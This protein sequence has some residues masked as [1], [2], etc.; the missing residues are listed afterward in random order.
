MHNFPPD[1]SSRWSAPPP[2]LR[3]LGYT[4][5]VTL[6]DGPWRSRVQ[7]A[8]ETFLE[9]PVDDVLKGF[10][11]RAGLPAPGH[12]LS[13]W[14]AELTHD[15][16][17][18]W[19]SGLARLGAS[20]RDPAYTERARVLA[21]GWAATLPADGD[22][23]MTTYRWEKT[24]CGLV[25][26]AIYGGWDEGLEL[27]R[28]ITAAA[29]RTI[30]RTRTIPVPSEF[31]GN[32]PDG[33][34]E[35]YT[36]AENLYRGYLAGGDEILRR[37]AGTWHYDAFWDHFRTRPAPGSR[38]HPPVWLHAYSHVNSFASAAAAYGV[39]GDESF[40]DVAANGH[41]WVVQTQCYAT[42]GFG[43]GELTVPDDG[44]LG[45][46]L[47]WRTDTAEI[48]C[49]SWAA[50]KLCTALTTA[51]GQ[52]RY[53]DWAERLAYSGIGA[54]PPVR[55]DGTSP[56]YHDYRLGT[57]TMLPFWDHWPCC[58]G[59]YLQAVAHVPDLLY[60]AAADGVA[61]GLY[62][63]SELRLRHDEVDVVLRQDTAFPDEDESRIAVDVSA[64]AR[65]ALRLRVPSWSSGLEVLVDGR[66]ADVS[67][68]DEGWLT[69]DREWSGRATVTVRLGARLVAAPVDEWHPDRVAFSYGPV[70]LAQE[71]AFGRPIELPTPV[72]TVDLD[73]VFHRVGPGPR[74]VV[75]QP[76]AQRRPQRLV[77][78]LSDFGY[79]TPYRVYHDVDHGRLV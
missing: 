43:P 71:A 32:R 3:E 54:V 6:L 41:D 19:I 39:T 48:V 67:W 23:G 63:P 5:A 57:A 70:V 59:T 64:P 4:G 36:L 62:L 7:D 28:R 37:F 9:L 8:G 45:R 27:A 14:A 10:R 22:A 73:E 12:D 1:G 25:D 53:L 75:D 61:V 11:R 58:S 50:F 55:L 49:G 15:T 33:T 21:E 17:G 65:F 29:E 40:L 66:P 16:L 20:L 77:R 35:W 51:T 42:G 56:Y 72:E 2:R 74:Y 69:L 79:R 26:L 78:P 52:A 30:D 60:F 46:A 38:W 68:T 47:E 34:L 13:G 18:Q 31:A 44:S 76:D 24:L